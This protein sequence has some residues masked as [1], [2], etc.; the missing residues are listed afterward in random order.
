[1]KRRTFFSKGIASLLSTTLLAKTNTFGKLSDNNSSTS[2]MKPK[3][4][5]MRADGLVVPPALAS[6]MTIGVTAPASGI[7]RGD[8]DNGIE[9]LRQQGIGVVLGKCLYK[10]QSSGFLSAPDSERANEFMQFV[11]RDDIHGIMC[12]RGGYGVMRILPMLNYDSIRL[13]A[14]PIIGFS[15]ITALLIA[16]YNQSRLVGFHGTVASSSFD[17]ITS[18]SFIK[19]LLTQPALPNGLLTSTPSIS[20]SNNSSIITTDS[21][22]QKGIDTAQIGE[23]ELSEPTTPI[24]Y[25]DGSYDVIYE[26]KARG[27]ITGGNLTMICSTLGTPYEVQTDNS[28]LFLEDVME[29]PYKID[30]MVTQLWLAGKLEKVRG[31]VLGMFKDCNPFYNNDKIKSFDMT[32]A[33]RDV[34]ES[35]LAKY[36]I[37][38]LANLPIGHVRSKLTLPIGILAELDTTSKSLTILEPTVSK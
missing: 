12:A 20:D 11:E 23:R 5:F 2:L 7:N 4:G 13:N 24:T 14:K 10:N 17:T 34:F 6:G 37:P 15:D 27:I 30:R 38:V 26:G 1:M 28:I 25:Q 31:V 36:S 18:S 21:I 29:E 8:L 32:T 9:F 33:V 16:I 19:T 22:R 35:R 3:R